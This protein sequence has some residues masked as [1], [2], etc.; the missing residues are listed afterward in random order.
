MMEVGTF[1]RPAANAAEAVG[2]CLIR[3]GSAG[4]G[5]LLTPGESVWSLV[6]LEKLMRHV[7]TSRTPDLRGSSRS[8]NVS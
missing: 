8:L 1:S 2:R 7:S 3:A 4:D 6:N 5:S